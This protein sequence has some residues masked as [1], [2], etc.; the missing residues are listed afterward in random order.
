MKKSGKKCTPKECKRFDRSQAAHK[1]LSDYHSRMYKKTEKRRHW[2]CDGYHTNVQRKQNSLG[3]LLTPEEKK[4]VY[5]NS[6]FY[7]DN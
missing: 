6:E 7:Y 1:R 4:A 3:R 2:V 5:R